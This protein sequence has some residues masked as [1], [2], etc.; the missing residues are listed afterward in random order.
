MLGSILTSGCSVN[1]Y[2]EPGQKLYEDTRIT[3]QEDIHFVNESS[4]RYG[5]EEISQPKPN[6][7]LPLWIH[8]K[9]GNPNKK[10]G[11]GNFLKKLNLKIN[12]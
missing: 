10:R 11:L 8:Y 5:L 7:K 2:L 6:S 1:K 4:L 12:N 9:F 3:F